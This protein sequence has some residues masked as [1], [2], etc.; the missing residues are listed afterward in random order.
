MLVPKKKALSLI[1]KHG[2]VESFIC[3]YGTVYDTPE[4]ALKKIFPSWSRTKED[5]AEIEK[6]DKI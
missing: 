6:V 1:E 2:L 3:K 5:I 4:G